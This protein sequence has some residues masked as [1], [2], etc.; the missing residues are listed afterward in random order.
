[1]TVRPQVVRYVVE[2]AFQVLEERRLVE[3][4]VVERNLFVEDGKIAR[5]LDVRGRP[6]NE[7]ERIVV[8]AG[9][10]VV[11]AAFRERLILVVRAAVRK[12]RRGNVEDAF[13]GSL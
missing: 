1:Q 9:P 7:P 6:E 12:L 8:E 11:V 13:A 4:V 2:R 10:S 3:L 5:F